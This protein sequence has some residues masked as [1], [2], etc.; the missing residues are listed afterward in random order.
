MSWQL[1]KRAIPTYAAKISQK[2]EGLEEAYREEQFIR[3]LDARQ[4]C[5]P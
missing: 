2:I 5:V 1:W 4:D 3:W